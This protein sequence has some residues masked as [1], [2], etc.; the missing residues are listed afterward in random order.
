MEKR[1]KAGKEDGSEQSKQSK[2]KQ[3]KRSKA[4]KGKRSHEAKKAVH[5]HDWHPVR[6]TWCYKLPGW[7]RIPPIAGWVSLG[8]GLGTLPPWPL[9]TPLRAARLARA[10]AGDEGSRR[11]T[12]SSFLLLLI[13]VLQPLLI[14]TSASLIC[15][16]PQRSAMLGSE[17]WGRRPRLFDTTP[18]VVLAPLHT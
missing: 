3:N 1:H 12:I 14:T 9:P 11:F 6:A 10:G 17:G 4:S 16:W 15:G 13:R 18:Q 2:A 7:P 8:G 5:T